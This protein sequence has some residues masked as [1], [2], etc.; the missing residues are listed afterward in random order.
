MVRPVLVLVA[1]WR[2]VLV[3]AIPYKKGGSHE[4]PFALW[5]VLCVGLCGL[6]EKG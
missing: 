1:P 4:P 6:D 5:L 2:A 3:I